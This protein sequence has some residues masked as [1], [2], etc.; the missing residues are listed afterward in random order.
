MVLKIVIGMAVGSALGGLLGA[1]R[2]CADDGCPL[3]ANPLRG[4][5]WG[6]LMGLLAV[7]AITAP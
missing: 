5:I 1:T 4:A 7:L 2:S 6:G 3:T